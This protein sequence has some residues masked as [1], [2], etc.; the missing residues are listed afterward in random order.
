MRVLRNI[1][2]GRNAGAGFPS[3]KY[4]STAAKLAINAC[5]RRRFLRLAPVASEG[6][7]FEL[8]PS[9]MAALEEDGGA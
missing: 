1:R 8:T 3:G 9:G 5:L 6:S 2:A 4:A 7:V